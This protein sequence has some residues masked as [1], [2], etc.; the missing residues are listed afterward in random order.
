MDINSF[1][2]QYAMKIRMLHSLSLILI[3]I[4][5][6]YAC[7]DKDIEKQPQSGLLYKSLF[8]QDLNLTDLT[9]LVEGDFDLHIGKSIGILDQLSLSIIDY[10][11]KK[12]IKQIPFD[13]LKTSILLPSVIF[14]VEKEPFV[15]LSKGESNC[16]LLDA[17]GN[18]KWKY[19]PLKDEFAYSTTACDLDNNG[20]PEIYVA[21][22]IGLYRLK[23]NGGE[24]LKLIND[25]IY[26]V[27]TLINDK[28]LNTISFLT[29]NNHF[30]SMDFHGN[31]IFD[32]LLPKKIYDFEIVSWP[33][34]NS[35]LTFSKENIYIIDLNGN[36][37][38]EYRLDKKIYSIKGTPVD[39]FNKSN[40]CL[41]IVA[42][43]SS[44]IG[45]SMLLVFSA[46][47][48]L[49]YKELI[50]STM[51]ILPYKPKVGTNESLLVGNG[52][53]KVYEYTITP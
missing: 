28:G 1:N 32:I 16:R 41:S 23:I 33:A 50:S 51:A 31:I 15:I 34:N 26:R 52:P 17:Y 7:N 24:P 45:K 43:F 3:S 29:S 12:L 14:N 46:E 39:F 49:L 25:K 19:H 9:G 53:G 5:I 38:I 20:K 4:I 42:K 18:T 47:G 6:L 36:I 44:S 11:S 13:N 10:H 8:Y 27:E 35:I 48:K 40:P 22:N 37:L 2:P 30:K 21:T